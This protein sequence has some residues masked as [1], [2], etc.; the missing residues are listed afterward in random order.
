MNK[1]E[2]DKYMDCIL[3]MTM[4]VKRGGISSECYLNNLK[5]IVK[6]LISDLEIIPL[7]DNNMLPSVTTY[8]KDYDS[9]YFGDDAS[10]EL[11]TLKSGECDTC[12]IHIDQLKELF[13][14]VLQ[15]GWKLKTDK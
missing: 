14:D 13:D 7:G 4:D 9:V 5:L 3:S 1:E 8:T 12:V 2:F 11:I 10:L 15:S 6:N